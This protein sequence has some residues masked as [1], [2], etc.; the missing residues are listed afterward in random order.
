LKAEKYDGPWQAYATFWAGLAEELDIHI[1]PGDHEDMITTYAEGVG[2]QL[3]LCI[4][5][6]LGPEHHGYSAVGSA[7]GISNRERALA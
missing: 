4:E 3:S 5:R 2:A 1:V 7:T 6:G